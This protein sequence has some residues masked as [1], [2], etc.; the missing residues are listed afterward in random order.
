MTLIE[1][2]ESKPYLWDKRADCFKDKIEK[3]KA[4]K[5]LYV[6]LEEDFQQKNKKIVQVIH[7]V[8]VIIIF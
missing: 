1:V 8:I 5:E 6:F 4:W 3:Q 7:L 2:V